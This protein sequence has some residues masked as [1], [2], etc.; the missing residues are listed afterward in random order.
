MSLYYTSLLHDHT[1]LNEARPPSWVGL[2]VVVVVVS[3]HK[4]GVPYALVRGVATLTGDTI[5]SPSNT[6]SNTLLDKTTFKERG[7]GVGA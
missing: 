4:G 5:I 2:A 6:L 7:E 3:L 1:S